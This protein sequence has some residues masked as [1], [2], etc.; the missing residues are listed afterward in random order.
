M[1]IALTDS[2]LAID[3]DFQCTKVCFD[4]IPYAKVMSMVGD[5]KLIRYRDQGSWHSW[6]QCVLVVEEFSG[7]HVGW[8]LV[9]APSILEQISYDC[10]I[11]HLFHKQSS[12]N[13]KPLT[14]SPPMILDN[15][16]EKV[17]ALVAF[18][19]IIQ[20]KHSLVCWDPLSF[21]N[22]NLLHFDPPNASSY[23]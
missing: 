16:L 3:I 18:S 15:L 7:V 8:V 22:K 17:W 21:A 9:S 1:S 5:S 6:D 11:H 13:H 4:W 14:S 19:Y 23:T 12:S 20:R 2:L 10:G